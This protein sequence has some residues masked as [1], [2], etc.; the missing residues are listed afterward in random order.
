[1]QSTMDIPMVMPNAKRDSMLADPS[2][3]VFVY[4]GEFIDQR[5]SKEIVTL[6]DKTVAPNGDIGKSV[7]EGLERALAMQGYEM[8]DTAPLIL[9]GEVRNWSATLSGGFSKNLES[10]AA[11]FV[12]ILDPANKRV[13]SGVYKGFASIQSP[14]ISEA[15]IR[16]VLQTSMSEAVRQVTA[17]AQ[18]LKIL[19]AF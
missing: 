3:G 13:Y 4:V 1:M 5:A 10:D 7:A 11:V 15:D 8:T 19:S 14:S 2:R 18:L 9:S 17:D 16:S 6:E 12:E